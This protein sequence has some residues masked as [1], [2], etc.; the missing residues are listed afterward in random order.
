MPFLYLH[1]KDNFPMFATNVYTQRR[2][3]LQ[4]QL[5]KG[6]LLFLGNEYTGMNYADNTYHFRQ[7]STFLYYF[8]IDQNHLAAIIDLDEGKTI[9]FGNELSVEYVVWMGPQ[10]TIK[11]QAEKVGVMTTLPYADL[12]SYLHKASEQNR[13]IHYLPPYRDTHRIKLH[14]WL[15]IPLTEIAAKASTPLIQTIVNQR[16]IKSK[17]EIVEMEKAVNVSREMHVTAMAIAKE[18]MIEAELAGK[19]EG[20]AVASGGNL[21]YPVILTVNGQTLHNHYHGN[22]LQKGQLVLGDFGAETAMHYAGDI[23]R[24]YPVDRKFTAR[25]KDIY[26][27]V[28]DAE[29]SCIEAL[30]PGRLFRDLHLQ[31]AKIKLDGLK[32]LGLTKGNMD[33][34]LEAG[35]FGLFFPHGLGHMIGL[36]VHD[37]EN[38][39]E[40]YV[41]Y[42]TG[43]ERSKLF[44]LKSLRLARELEE[45]FVLTVEPGIYFIPE[46]I[47]MWR[48]EGKFKDFINYDKV[49][50]YKDFGGIRI[51][52]NCLVTAT[53]SRTLGN[54][55]PKTIAEIEAIR[56][57]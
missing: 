9:I 50:T 53:G 5:D 44:G 1:K 45:G 20:I 57:F 14:Q 21:A 42:R 25:Q 7:D 51:E 52:D 26:T 8:G 28:L 47:D 29:E 46:L 6:I 55:I 13:T 34:A 31:A 37:M 4:K 23:T 18:G 49:E 54:P 33:D 16:S 30:K 36:D 40:Q 19:V 48:A 10:P 27:I 2:A 24:T 32:A 3:N 11:A 35:A 12:S 17:E 38:L 15:N 43:L 41:G 56:A 39:G 22:T